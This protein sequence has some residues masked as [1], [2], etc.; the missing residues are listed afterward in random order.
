M[1]AARGEA[2][3]G[4]PAAQRGGYAPGARVLAAAAQALE[5]VVREGGCTAETALQQLQLDAADRG[6]VRAIHSGTLRWYLRLAPLLDALLAPGQRVAP[7]VAAVLVVALHQIEYS[8]APPA[9]VVNI[10]VDAVRVLGR[11]G[12]SGFVNAL[13]RRYL[14]EREDLLARIDRSEAARLAH[15]R[16]TRS[17]PRTTRRRR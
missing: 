7:P 13:L 16:P 11:Q 15:P 2:D 1:S 10:A 17:S 14:R 3:P 8:R 12:A 6:A 4:A 9:S 5:A